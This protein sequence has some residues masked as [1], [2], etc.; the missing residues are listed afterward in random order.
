MMKMLWDIPSKAPADPRRGDSRIAR[1]KKDEDASSV[2]KRLGFMSLPFEGREGWG[3]CEYEDAPPL[4]I[5]HT[6]SPPPPMA[7]PP[8]GG[9]LMYSSP[10]DS[11]DGEGVPFCGGSKPPPYENDT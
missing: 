8:L 6:H 3:V 7:E 9:S 4:R 11:R 1:R 2:P 10:T 5:S